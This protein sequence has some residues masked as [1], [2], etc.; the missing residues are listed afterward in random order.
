MNPTT[1][2]CVEHCQGTTHVWNYVYNREL[3]CIKGCAHET[4]MLGCYIR[5]LVNLVCILGDVYENV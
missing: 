1:R 3:E 4:E 5:E 2:I